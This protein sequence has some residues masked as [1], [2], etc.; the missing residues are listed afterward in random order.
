MFTALLCF[1]GLQSSPIKD[2]P[3]EKNPIKY[4]M[5]LPTEIRVPKSY[6]TGKTI[7]KNE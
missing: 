2:T 6:E 1:I 5:L 7:Y 3:I 4:E